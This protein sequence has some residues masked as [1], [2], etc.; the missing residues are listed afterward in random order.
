MNE[1]S[2]A[3]LS[4][5]LLA[6]KGG[7]KPAM[8]P[9]HGG[10]LGAIGG[11]PEDTDASSEGSLDDL[12]WNDMGDA[13][14]I[15]L[16]PAPANKQTAAEARNIDEQAGAKLAEFASPQS[17]ARDQQNVLAQRLESNSPPIMPDAI[18]SDEDCSDDEMSDDEDFEATSLAETEQE[19]EAFEAPALEEVDP[20][21]LSPEHGLNLDHFKGPENFA[22]EEFAAEETVVAAP[23]AVRAV[24]AAKP[25]RAHRVSAAEQGKRAAFTLRLDPERHL[26]L[27][28]A[29]TIRGRSAQQIVTDALDALLGDMPDLESLAAQVQRPGKTS[30]SDNA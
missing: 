11:T 27:R 6:R 16:T 30:G 28:L 25:P 3:S 20:L 13:D 7:A 23:V 26:K 8:R 5:S 2:F 4:P 22:E 17:P 19:D 21:D 15:Q 10:M 18:M 29:S 1:I 14:V 12:G 9:Q 24:T